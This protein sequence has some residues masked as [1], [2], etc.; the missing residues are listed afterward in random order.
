MTTHDYDPQQPPASVLHIAFRGLAP[1]AAVE[2]TIR[3]RAAAFDPDRGQ[4]VQIV[5]RT[6]APRGRRSR[7]RGR[8]RLYRARVVVAR[9]DGQRLA[10]QSRASDQPLTAIGEAFRAARRAVRRAPARPAALPLA[11]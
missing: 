7:R 11:C 9:G 4:I 1:T 6:E 2:R 8:A 10:F 3:S 5:V